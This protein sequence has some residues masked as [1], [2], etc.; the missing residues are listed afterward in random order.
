MNWNN[1]EKSWNEFAALNNVELIYHERNLF[2]TITCKYKLYI[3]AEYGESCFSGALW[4]S[5][6]GHNKN[7]TKISTKFYTEE[8]L[9]DF[10]LKSGGIKNFF[11]KNKLNNFEKNIAQDLKELNGKS[12]SLKD[13]VLEIELNVIISSKHEF[14]KITE[15]TR[16]IKTS[17]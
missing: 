1:I 17:R 16:K 15:L 6:D 3:Q 11:S 5:Q 8:S 7:Q 9:R 10:E 2:H 13:S 14:D 12:L 4:K